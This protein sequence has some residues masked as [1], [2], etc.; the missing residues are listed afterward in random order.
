MI[1][2]DTGPIVAL[3]NDRDH[4]HRQCRQLLEQ[5]PDPLLVPVT[6]ATE[7]CILLE[8]RR[9]TR[10]ERLFLADIRAGR[11]TLIESLSA[12][13]DRVAELVAKYDNLPLG[14]VDASVIALAE[15]LRIT[16]VVTLDRRDFGAVRPAHVATVTLLP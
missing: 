1:L 9:G 5:L 14:T 13:L 4:H 3:I 11:F 8:R 16:T 2:V 10:A 15:R 7:A 6:V 12:D